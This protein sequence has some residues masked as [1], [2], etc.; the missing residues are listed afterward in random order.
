MNSEFQQLAQKVDQ[1]ASLARTMRA[2]NTELRLK[3]AELTSENAK[4]TERVR[5]A[6]DRVTAILEKLPLAEQEAE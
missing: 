4:L 3:I 6:H 5:S 2:E 1:L